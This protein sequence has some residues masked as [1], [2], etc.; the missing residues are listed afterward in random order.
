[1]KPSGC[2]RSWNRCCSWPG[3]RA[4]PGRRSW[5]RSSWCSGCAS[6]LACRSDGERAADMHERLT[7]EAPG[8]GAGA[9]A[10]SGPVAREPAG[11]RLQ[12][13]P[14]G[15]SDHG[16][17]RPR[18]RIRDAGRAGPRVSAS[19]A[20]DLA[21]VF[22]PFYRSAKARRRPGVGLGLAVVERIAAVFGGTIRAESEP[23]RGSRFILRLPDATSTI[24]SPIVA[25]A[26]AMTASGDRGG[27]SELVNP[28]FGLRR[29]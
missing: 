14:G 7:T 4:R 9:A 18:G 3:R 27:A 16:G 1:M 23:G 10:A 17:G 13:Q 28:R 8:V 2:V 25:T 20:E 5:S 21:H 29:P 11:Q 22:E 15:D 26:G 24:V 12:V 6:A 19:N